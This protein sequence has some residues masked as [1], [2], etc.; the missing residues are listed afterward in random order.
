MEVIHIPSLLKKTEQTETIKF[1]E[2]I[3]DL[4]TLTPVR[5]YLQVTHHG[6][7][8]EVKGELETIITLT[9][10]R[11]LKQY[12]YKLPIAPKEL[13]WLQEIKEQKD[14]FDIEVENS[15]EDLVE[16]LPPDGY[17]NPKEWVYEQLCLA[18]PPRKVCDKDCQGI[19][20][21]E[22]NGSSL[23]IDRRW[24]GLESIKKQLNRNN[25]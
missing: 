11:C 9:C 8:L 10:D 21:S 13:I 17:F 3:S 4:E 12:N 14:L 19:K 25:N 18:V 20:L 1:E 23:M 22:K 6:N 24:A 5:G 16:T 7:Y 15:V 2:F